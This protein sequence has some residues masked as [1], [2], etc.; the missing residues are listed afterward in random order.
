MIANKKSQ[1]MLYEESAGDSPL[2]MSRKERSKKLKESENIR[3]A[4]RVS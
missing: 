4:G 1:G 2:R 3:A